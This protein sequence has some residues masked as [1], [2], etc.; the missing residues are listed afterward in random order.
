MIPFLHFGHDW[1]LLSMEDIQN[2]FIDMSSST[3]TMKL[4]EEMHV[5]IYSCTQYNFTVDR[6]YTKSP[7]LIEF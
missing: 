4:I 3:F 7:C 6:I 2:D 1:N 5:T